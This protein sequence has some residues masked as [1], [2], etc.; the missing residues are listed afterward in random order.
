[1][2]QSYAEAF[3]VSRN[4]KLAAK[5]WSKA[6]NQG[7]AFAQC[8][9][10]RAYEDGEG[11][12]KNIPKAKK[13]YE[14][15]AKQ[16]DP[17]PKFNLARLKMKARPYSA[18][19]AAFKSVVPELKKLARRKDSSAMVCLAECAYHGWGMRLS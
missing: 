4:L 16:G 2:G 15:S 19:Q 7:H 8:N 13:L 10:G 12:R 3:G 18:A 9:L 6:A 5:W 11:V 1:M 14:A 17:I